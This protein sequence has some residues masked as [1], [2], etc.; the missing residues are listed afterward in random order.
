[1]LLETIFSNLNTHMLQGIL[2]HNTMA[3]AYDFLGLRGYA[4]FHNYQSCEE[5]SDMQHL[6]HYYFTHYHKLIKKNQMEQLAIIPESWFKYTTM[7]VDQG[8][9]RSAIKELITKWIEWEKETKTLYQNMRQELI[10]IGEIAATIEIDKYILNVSTELEHAE[11]ELISLNTINYDL[12][13]IESWQK[14][15]C[16]KYKK[17]LG[18]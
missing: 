16:K 12:I 1:M 17:K 10:S 8:T 11:R 13:E 14:P 15:M 7:D 4:R 3:E 2:I 6:I 5:M 9:K 18:W